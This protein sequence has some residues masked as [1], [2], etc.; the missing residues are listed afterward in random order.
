MGL[1]WSDPGLGLADG[2]RPAADGAEVQGSYDQRE[3]SQDRSAVAGGCLRGLAEMAG[4]AGD[5]R[6]L[7]YRIFT[8]LKKDH[9]IYSVEVRVM[10]LKEL[11]DPQGKAVMGGLQS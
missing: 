5:V 7:Y 4:G 10:P 2:E 6:F 3:S 11:L 8:V 1:V 9:M